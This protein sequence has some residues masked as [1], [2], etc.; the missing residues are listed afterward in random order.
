[1]AYPL[2][3]NK[4]FG[5]GGTKAARILI[6]GLGNPGEEYARTRHNAGLMAVELLA[7]R[8][9][10][11]LARDRALGSWVARR[12]GTVLARTGS[13]MNVSGPPVARLARKFGVSAPLIV[14]DDLDLPLGTI[15]FRTQGTAGGHHGLESIIEALGTDRFPRLK[16]G[17]GRPTSRQGIV[18]WVLSPFAPEEREML[19]QAL[20]RAEQALHDVIELGMDK[21]ISRL[22]K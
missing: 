22:S 17:I 18:E 19:D 2:F 4:L 1:M 3:W 12:G 13:F 5:M 8:L 11:R 6:V 10:L 7:A 9:K 20:D 16:I 21:A 15:R 14:N